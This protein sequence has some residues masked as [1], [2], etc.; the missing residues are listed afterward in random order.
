MYSSKTGSVVYRGSDGG[1]PLQQFIGNVDEYLVC[2]VCNGVLRNPCLSR[3]CDTLICRS[4]AH[5]CKIA[6]SNNARCP[7]CN[8]LSRGHVA[9]PRHVSSQLFNLQIR[10]DN[11]HRGCK[12]VLR[13]S[14]LGHH[15]V[16]CAYAPA[17]CKFP[18][19]KHNSPRFPIS[20]I[21]LKQHELDCP[22]NTLKKPPS[23]RPAANGGVIL[24]SPKGLVGKLVLHREGQHITGSEINSGNLSS[25]PSNAGFWSDRG[26]KSHAE[27]VMT[28]FNSGTG[29]G[30]Q[31]GTVTPA[32]IVD[33]R[34]Q[35]WRE[36]HNQHRQ[37]MQRKKELRRS[38]CEQPPPHPGSY[39]T[40][41]PA[42]GQRMELM[43]SNRPQ[44]A[45]MRVKE[46]SSGQPAGVS[47]WRKD[48]RLQSWH[49]AI[50]KR[51]QKEKIR[52]IRRADKDADWIMERRKLQMKQIRKL[53]KDD[54]KEEA[55]KQ[56]LASENQVAATAAA[57]GGLG[58][59]ENALTR[60]GI[61]RNKSS[62]LSMTAGTTYRN[63]N[64]AP[65][66]ERG[67]QNSPTRSLVRKNSMEDI[68]QSTR[69]T[70]PLSWQ[71]VEQPKSIMQEK[72]AVIARKIWVKPGMFVVEHL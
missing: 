37:S 49:D 12:S 31:Q 19:C 22:H 11:A 1:Y 65:G 8:K 43:E 26:P 42:M 4:C 46:A 9:P 33:A 56:R 51:K 32:H 67:T 36:N 5:K 70:D 66:Q 47:D 62:Q 20:R 55:Q 61:L 17:V 27:W 28:R 39:G 53:R 57:M 34:E 21:D 2:R 71:P 7:H 35:A 59:G 72:D 68:L 63:Q 13:L 29:G 25:N 50:I 58:A 64:Q 24:S 45:P 40:Y 41:P 14:D 38:G 54:E 44:S 52:A 10:C 23:A 16:E 6:R 15:V 69:R 18:G 48:D 3:C 60:P 30:S